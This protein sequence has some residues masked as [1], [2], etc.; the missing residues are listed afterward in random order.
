MGAGLNLARRSATLKFLGRQTGTTTS[1]D[2][3]A[4]ILGGL[5][6]GRRSGRQFFAEGRWEVK[7]GE[8]LVASVGILF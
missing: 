2:M 5:R 6:F 7:G 1:T 8:Q 3:G 4:N